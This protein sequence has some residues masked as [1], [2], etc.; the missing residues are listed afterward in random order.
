LRREGRQPWVARTPLGIND[1]T[2]KASPAQAVELIQA[3]ERGKLGQ[4][5]DCRAAGQLQQ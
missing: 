3:A 2:V 1:V 5:R 4:A